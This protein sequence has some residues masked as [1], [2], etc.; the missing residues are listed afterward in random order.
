MIKAR[1]DS[2]EFKRDFG[3]LIERTRNPRGLLAG[4]GREAANL[5][6]AHFRNKDRR[7]PNKLGGKRQH[8][9]AQVERSVQAPVVSDAIKM[10]EISITHPAFAQKLF[11]GRIRAARVRNLAIPQEPEA[12]GRSPSVF[13]RELGVKLFFVKVRDRAVLAR[14]IDGKGLQ[15]EYLLTPSVNQLPDPTA[16]PEEK[17][18]E[19]ALLS[20]AESIVD[21]E[22]RENRE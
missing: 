18:F 15:V 8:F 3:A 19:E 9:W 7:E 4:V 14:N 16:L 6:R 12:Y 20:R 21:R 1:V 13:E 10:V 17:A 22:I 2:A 11:G 5:L